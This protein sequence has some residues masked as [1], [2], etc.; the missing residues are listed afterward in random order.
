MDQ[1]T[2]QDGDG[3]FHGAHADPNKWRAVGVMVLFALTIPAVLAVVL[4]VKP[5][6]QPSPWA[7]TAASLG[8]TPQQLEWGEGVFTHTC[9][10]CHS[11]DAR[12]IP[13][14]GKP[15]RNSAFVQSHSDD[16]LLSVIANGRLPGDPDNTTGAVMP[17]RAG[18]PALDNN[19]LMNVVYYLRTLQDP[20]EPTVDLTEWVVA[21]LPGGDSGPGHEVFVAA[22]S[23]CHGV[24]GEGMEGLGKPLDT[25]TFVESKTDKELAAFI[26]TGRPIWDAANTTGVDMPP[27]GGNPALSAE[28]L[29]TI[30]A[31]IRSLHQK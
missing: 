5:K 18:N 2:R 6:P 28:E 30:I 8:V 19:H 22:C 13:R 7:M 11:K 3:S 9:S 17:P 23:A 12:G 27:K 25:S 24:N 10:V 14:L 21:D 31:Y 16:E 26:K 1:S 29:S 15:L 4:L 20:E